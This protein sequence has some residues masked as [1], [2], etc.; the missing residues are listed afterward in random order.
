MCCVYTYHDE[1]EDVD[2][3]RHVSSCPEKET[4]EMYLNTFS[5]VTKS[6][7]INN[8]IYIRRRATYKYFLRYTVPAH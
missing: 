8:Y 6:T 3:D 4:Q 1:E 5:V 2:R 7:V